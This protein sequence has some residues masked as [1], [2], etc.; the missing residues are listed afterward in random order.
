MK[1]E[2]VEKCRACEGTGIYVGVCERYGKVG[3]VCYNCKGTGKRYQKHTYEE[4]TGLVNRDDVVT[5][6]QSNVGVDVDSQ[7]DIGG[8]PYT[9]WLEKKEFPPKSELRKYTCPAWWYQSVDYDWKPKWKECGSGGMFLMCPS[10]GK[11]DK[12]WERW[13]KEFGKT[14][15]V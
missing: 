1:V 2:W 13:D 9:E 7:D 10:F 4:F 5:I 15:E 11:K 12:C 6:L 8:M 3:V 14:M